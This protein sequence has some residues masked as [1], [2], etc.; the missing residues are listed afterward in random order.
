MLTINEIKSIPFLFIVGRGRSGTSL[1]Q[2]VLGDHPNV[3]S[4]NESPFILTLKKKYSKIETWDSKLLDSFI[5]D[6]YEDLKF[7][8]FWKIDQQT[9]RRSIGQYSVEQLTFSVLCKIVYLNFPSSSEKRNILWL[10][11]K[12]PIYS[13]FINDLIEIFPEAKFIHLVRDYRDNIISRRKSF[14]QKDVAIL[15]KSWVKFNRIINNSSK[16]NPTLFYRIRYEDLVTAPEKYISEM[17]DFLH[18]RFEVQMLSFHKTTNKFFN[19]NKDKVVDRILGEI[20]SNL[21]KPI[22]TEQINKWEKKLN[23]KE[24]EIVDY[25]AG[26]Y[27]LEYNYIQTTHKKNVLFFIISI[28]TNIQFLFTYKITVMYYKTPGIIRVALKK[29]FVKLNAWFGYYNK[30]N[31]VK[32]TYRKDTI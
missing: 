4:T 19:E 6:L 1:L 21:L 17:C 15:A 24:I 16:K 7:S 2:A 13:L 11:D 27:A 5:T 14:G 26:R 3:I 29:I 31:R 32:F 25:L 20:H 23:K 22:N 18:I 8:H 9:L 10:V 28:K 30:F 12:N